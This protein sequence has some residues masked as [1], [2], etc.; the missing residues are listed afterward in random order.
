[1]ELEKC[2][3]FARQRA[4]EWVWVC[5]LVLDLLCDIACWT[6]ERQEA[7]NIGHRIEGGIFVCSFTFWHFLEY[8]LALHLFCLCLD[9]WNFA[10]ICCRFSFRLLSQTQFIN[11]NVT[12]FILLL[13]ISIT[14][15]R[16]CLWE[17][18]CAFA[19]QSETCNGNF[20]GTG[21]S[22]SGLAA[23]K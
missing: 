20:W 9:S 11:I 18:L 19:R 13:S 14:R 12:N 10:F 21:T 23:I 8:L 1:M 5:I 6:Y 4:I 22:I 2:L 3:I 15:L 7:S 16:L 17:A